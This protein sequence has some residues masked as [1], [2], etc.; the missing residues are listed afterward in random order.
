MF[1]EE[2]KKINI[3]YLHGSFRSAISLAI[4][5]GFKK[6]ILI[7]CDYT[8]EKAI[9]GHFYEKGEGINF[10]F[11]SI[12]EKK[13]LE[14]ASKYATIITITKSGKGSFLPSLTYEEFSGKKKFFKENL[15]LCD[16]SFLNLVK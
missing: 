2:C 3:N 4:Y 7:G 11:K 5:M 1:F 12:Y 15:D 10:N 9:A 16:K 6:I 13:F 14:T 8:H